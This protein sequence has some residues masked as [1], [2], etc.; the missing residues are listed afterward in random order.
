MCRRGRRAIGHG[1]CIGGRTWVPVTVVPVIAPVA[2]FRLKPFANAG[3]M[4][5]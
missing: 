1:R 2:V 3:L 4:L 5:F